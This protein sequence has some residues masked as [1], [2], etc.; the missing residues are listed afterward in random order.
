MKL[1]T[2]IKSVEAEVQKNKLI[3]RSRTPLKILSSAVLNGGLRDANCIVSV[4]VPEETGFDI[5]DNV[6]REAGDF[7]REETAQLGIPQDQLVGIMTAAKMKNVNIVTSK[8]EDITLTAIATAGVH[9][10]ATAGDEI[11]SKQSAFPPIKWGTI[12]IIVLVDGDLTDS[13]MVNAVSTVTEAKT[14][15]LRELD[16]RSR[17][18]GEIATGTVTDSVVLACTKRGRKIAYAGTATPLGELIGKSVREAVKEALRNQENIVSDRPLKRRLKERGITVENMTTLFSQ[19]SSVLD[20][21]AEK[22]KQF[23]EE[24]EQV[25]CDQNIAALVIAG[26]RLDEDAKTGLIPENPANEYGRNFVL[27]KILQK[28]V[29]DYLSKDKSSYKYVRPDYL[30][31][32]F[33]EKMGWFTRSILSAV[34]YA[35]YSDFIENYSKEQKE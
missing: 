6:H 35:V 33:A 4:H 20:E 19:I 30:S 14:V 24:I 21:N 17:F 8:F 18:S 11:A 32:I 23:I 34:M 2:K 3:L 22:R 5:D 29:T 16:V 12:N 27:N 1:E 15:A 31:S 28:A 25:L 10:A 13:C 9:F 7:L 26:I